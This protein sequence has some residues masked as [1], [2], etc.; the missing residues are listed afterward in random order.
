MSDPKKAYE[1][2]KDMGIEYRDLRDVAKSVIGHTLGPNSKLNAAE[3][4]NLRAFFGQAEPEPEPKPEP[5]PELGPEIEFDPAEVLE[6]EA[7]TP[8]PTGSHTF[9]SSSGNILT[10]PKSTAAAITTW[11]T[12]LPYNGPAPQEFHDSRMLVNGKVRVFSSA[13]CKK[14]FDL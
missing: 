10:V 3:Q 11:L 7:V 6:T 13:A 5:E 1:L 2:A 14:D 9:T 4:D 12:S 8:P